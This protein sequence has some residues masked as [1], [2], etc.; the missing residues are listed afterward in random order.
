MLFPRKSTILYIYNNLFNNAIK[1]NIADGKIYIKLAHNQ[2]IFQNTG[3]REMLKKD[4]IFERFKKGKN[5]EGTGLGLTIVK[6]ICSQYN[7]TI[8]YSFEAL[9][10]TFTVKF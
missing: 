1:H 7:Y 4:E 8:S 5:S 9:M 2:L 10:H 6:N 3:E